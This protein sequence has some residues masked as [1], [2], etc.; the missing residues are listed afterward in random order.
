LNA[1][2]AAVGSF[3]HGAFSRLRF[4]QDNLSLLVLLN[5][6]V[7]RRRVQLVWHCW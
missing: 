4:V 5:G 3:V 1:A 7:L 2:S 6:F